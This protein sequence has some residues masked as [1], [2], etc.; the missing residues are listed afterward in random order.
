MGKRRKSLK[1]AS[2]YLL[3]STMA[4][5]AVVTA[6]PFQSEASTN[7]GDLVL[8]AE[9][10]AGA[11]KWQISYEYRKSAVFEYPNIALFNQTKQALQEAKQA[12]NHVKG[13]NKVLLQTRLDQNVSSYVDRTAKYIDAVTTGK[14]LVAASTKLSENLSKG[15]VD[16]SVEA[17]YHQ[18]SRD[19]QKS[20]I[21]FGR[22]YGKS[23]RTELLNYY[24]KGAKEVR[25]K[26]A[27]PVSIKI[28]LDDFNAALKENN[29]EKSIYHASRL[30]KLFAAA[31]LPEGSAISKTLTASYKE[32]QKN[33]ENIVTVFKADST[34]STN[35]TI[36]GGTVSGLQK[37]NKTVVIVAGAGQYIKLAN[38]EIEGNLIIKGDS[39]GAGTVFLENVKVSK[40]NNAGGSIIVEDVADHSL[41]QDHVS[42][43]ELKINDTN[44]ANVIAG[45]GTAIK[46]VTVTETAGAS[47]TIN[48][49]S[50]SK[51]AFGN[52]EL[53]SNVSGN[54]N[55]VLL[56]GDFSESTVSV[57]G[58]GS[59]VKVAKDAVVK[60]VEVKTSAILE[61]EAGAN[62][63]AVN[64]EAAEKGQSIQLKGDLKNT[65][66]TIANA[67][68]EVKVAE[69]TVIKE[70]KKDSSVKE[71]VSVENNGKIEFSTGVQVTH[72]PPAQTTPPVV[73][74]TPPSTG[75]TT[76]PPPV[77]QTAPVATNVT[78]SGNVT[79]GAV[80]TGNYHYSD[81][82]SD[83]ESGTVFSWFRA[84]RA[85]GQNKTVIQGATGNTYT[86]T[87]DDVG[88]YLF[89][90]V[91]PKA[92]TGTAAGTEVISAGVG[93]VAAPANQDV[94]PPSITEVNAVDLD[95]NGVFNR[96]DQ[97]NF[98]FSEDLNEQ[99]K[100]AV[101]HE[102]E[103]RTD[104][105]G[106]GVTA[107]WVGGN[108]VAVTIQ[109]LDDVPLN[110]SS[111]FTISKENIY[112]LSGNH[113]GSNLTIDVPDYFTL[114]GNVRV[115]YN[116]ATSTKLLVFLGGTLSEGTKAIT[117]VA[118]LFANSEVTQISGETRTTIHVQSM[119]WNQ[120]KTALTLTIPETTFADGDKVDVH[121]VSG[122]VKDTHNKVLGGILATI[123][124]TSPPYTADM[125]EI[126][127]LLALLPADPS[128]VDLS[129][130]DRLR[131]D[132]DRING[133]ITHAIQLGATQQ[134][135]SALANY[136]RLAA[137]E[138]R[139]QELI[140]Q[141]QQQGQTVS[142]LI[143][144]GQFTSS[145][146]HVAVIGFNGTSPNFI[147][148]N[149]ITDSS[150]NENGLS[151]NLTNTSQTQATTFYALINTNGYLFI[152][153][154]TLADL[155]SRN[156]FSIQ[157]DNTYVPLQVSLPNG[158]SES[159]PSDS[160]YLNM[161]NENGGIVRAWVSNGTKV[162]VG[163]YNIQYLAQRSDMSY[164]LFKDNFIV[165][166]TNHNVSFSENDVAR[167]NFILSTHNTDVTYT[168][169]DVAPLYSLG[170]NYN[171]IT[172]ANVAEGVTTVSLTKGF[173]G[174]IAPTYKINKNQESWRISF[175]PNAIDLQGDTTIT[176]DD[177]L[178][179]MVDW[180]V[181]YADNK[182]VNMN[183]P[184]L[185][186]LNT[187]IKNASG[188]S[189][190]YLDK[191]SST[192]NPNSGGPLK[193]R[194]TLRTT[195]GRVFTKD[196]NVFSF[197]QL[198][199]SDITNGEII[200]GQAELTF[201]ALDS[202]IAIQS[203]TTTITIG[204]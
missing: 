9:K 192:T 156:A 101:E 4:V 160:V 132:V 196:V 183:S 10:L 202:P 79:V 200:S 45:Q 150:L 153:K 203:Y 178:G 48:L 46:K 155:Q 135:I 109:T 170:S 58:Q 39:T 17:A 99:S 57:T 112:D 6:N 83:P 138:Q 84:D 70:V 36:A 59:T 186:Y 107:E 197:S 54:S 174:T 29:V 81:A 180:D 66:V 189:L 18:L 113:P 77:T 162:P 193:G 73:T 15:L 25:E 190:Q 7:A 145:F 164:S 21:I 114:S 143:Q 34:D 1:K 137:A 157:V 71:E 163:T 27:Y 181:P 76:N 88:K 127:R 128:T 78:I 93:P 194:V 182:T 68:A 104:L 151:V 168:L 19:I 13:S 102:L 147:F 26:A 61:A 131:S 125:V 176:V 191:L 167:V 110:F 152:K 94:T 133:V 37:I 103:Q 50:Q 41:H 172:S 161:K 14:R 139:I 141:Q 195:D 187:D 23:T 69:N 129:G 49:E 52:V 201:E 117:N 122:A 130:L 134:Q 159:N 63:Q 82:E 171:P 98:T 118:D 65:V 75:G 33:Y 185:N 72:N 120:N 106:T 204:G 38:A 124:V 136:S 47:G 119:Q 32:S 51:G 85:D 62:V 30:E 166:D 53:A 11:L 188:Q 22:V 86:L 146:A 169:S 44:G 12:V 3:A 199:I 144:G 74:P 108:T 149:F 140:Q 165:S 148:T 43:E 123:K 154:F 24:V 105:F 177:Q 100:T 89:F 2:K 40:V 5:S 55:G 28:A 198:S 35:P 90:G 16:D 56:K 184:L 173:Y 80:L 116:Q 95:A 96:Y 67:N 20:A 111:T 92:S 91:T 179:I 42:A 115:P 87:S 142:F 60:E 121:F 158:V 175:F 97:V 31:K 64:L 8:K 126:G